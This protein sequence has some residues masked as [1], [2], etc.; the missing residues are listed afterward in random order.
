[1][2]FIHVNMKI[3][4]KYLIKNI[5]KQLDE[6]KICKYLIDFQLETLTFILAS[7]ID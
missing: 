5:I 2:I 1:M 7:D 6:Y 4:I 3:I